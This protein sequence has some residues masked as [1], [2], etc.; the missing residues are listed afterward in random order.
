MG[1]LGVPYGTGAIGPTCQVALEHV[2]CGNVEEKEAREPKW[3]TKLTAH[4]MAQLLS[5]DPDVCQKSFLPWLAMKATNLGDVLVYDNVVFDSN[6]QTGAITQRQLD[7]EYDLN[8]S[9]HQLDA[10]R[11]TEQ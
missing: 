2:K 11:Y 6:S 4:W 8:S 10:V 7:Y 9:P 1:M 3:L 5:H